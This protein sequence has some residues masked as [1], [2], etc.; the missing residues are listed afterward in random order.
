MMNMIDNLKQVLKY[1]GYDEVKHILI[2]K[3]LA[4]LCSKRLISEQFSE[5]INKSIYS[6]NKL[7]EFFER[8]CEILISKYNVKEN[9]VKDV[10]LNLLEEALTSDSLSDLDEDYVEDEY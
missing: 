7:R 5:I 8:L 9:I 3:I 2:R 10:A 4:Y 1:A 6:N